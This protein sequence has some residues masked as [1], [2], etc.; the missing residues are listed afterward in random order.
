MKFVKSDMSQVK[1]DGEKEGVMKKGII[2]QASRQK[3]SH[4]LVLGN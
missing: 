2:K 4:Y 3:A 1:G